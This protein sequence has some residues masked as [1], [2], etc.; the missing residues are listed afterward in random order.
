MSAVLRLWPSC[1]WLGLIGRLGLTWRLGL[2]FTRGRDCGFAG[3]R[4]S[5]F[6]RGHCRAQGGE[7]RSLVCL[8]LVKVDEYVLRLQAG[9]HSLD[10]G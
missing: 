3:E 6:T 10:A 7:D 9:P 4:G 8:L 2:V 5:G 1:G